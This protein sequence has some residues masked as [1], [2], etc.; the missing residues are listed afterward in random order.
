MSRCLKHLTKYFPF[1]ID[2]CVIAVGTVVA[3]DGGG[4]NNSYH[5]LRAYYTPHI[6]LSPLT[7]LPH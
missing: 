7:V 5:F 3:L 1:K 2:D 6:V 4:N